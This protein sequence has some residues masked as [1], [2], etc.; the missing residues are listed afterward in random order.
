MNLAVNNLLSRDDEGEGDDDD[1]QDSYVPDD[2]ISLL[3]S[4]MHP[5]HP[6]VI[7][8]G[9]TMFSEDMF[10]Y[11]SIRSRGSGT[12]SRLGEL[13]NWIISIGQALHSVLPK[14]MS[15]CNIIQVC[16]HT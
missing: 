16:Q 15:P 6:S 14:K 7:I 10:G 1:S 4:G 2:L 8:D 3:D 11:S 9:D 12:R 13:D 5:D